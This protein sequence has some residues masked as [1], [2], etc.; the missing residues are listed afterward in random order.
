MFNWIHLVTLAALILLTERGEKLREAPTTILWMSTMPSGRTWASPCGSCSH[1]G[2][3]PTHA[4]QQKPL[5]ELWMSEASPTGSTAMVRWNREIVSLTLQRSFPG[6]EEHGFF[7]MANPAGRFRLSG[8]AVGE[9]PLLGLE[10]GS[11]LQNATLRWPRLSLGLPNCFLDCGVKKSHTVPKS[12]GSR[13]RSLKVWGNWFPE[14]LLLWLL[15]LAVPRLLQMQKLTLCLYSLWK[16][17][18]SYFYKWAAYFY[19]LNL[20]S[21]NFS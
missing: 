7:A 12:L 1:S 8:H 6:G 18:W 19:G 9:D 2:D 20:L 5:R 13:Y 16:T 4:T 11:E 17:T 21:W 14:M 10:E 3:K 15:P